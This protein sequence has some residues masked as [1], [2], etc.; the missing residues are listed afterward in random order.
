MTNGGICL[1][2]REMMKARIHCVQRTY[3]ICTYWYY[4]FY[5]TRSVLEEIWTH[6]TNYSEVWTLIFSFSPP[7]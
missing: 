3:R 6:N 1:L 7:F 4:N 5:S 2:L